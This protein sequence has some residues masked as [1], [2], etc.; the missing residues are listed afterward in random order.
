MFNEDANYNFQLNR[1]VMWGHGDPEEIL[2][3]S[4]SIRDSESWVRALMKLAKKAK[5][6]GRTQAQIGYLR[7]SEFF[8]YD[9]DPRKLRT[10]QKAKELLIWNMKGIRKKYEANG[11]FISRD[12]F[13]NAGT[14]SGCATSCVPKTGI[15]FSSER[16]V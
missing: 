11:S 10:Y 13:Y 5:E 9:S 4:K 14:R 12:V 16:C 6:E 8:M 2:T 7:M 15:A 3:V 1:V